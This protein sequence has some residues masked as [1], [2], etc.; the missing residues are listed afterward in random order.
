MK[1]VVALGASSRVVHPFTDDC[2]LQGIRWD[3]ADPNLPSSS[4]RADT[5][6]AFDFTVTVL[7]GMEGRGMIHRTPTKFHKLD[8]GFRGFIEEIGRTVWPGLYISKGTVYKAL[9]ELDIGVAHYPLVQGARGPFENA[10]YASHAEMRCNPRLSYA[11]YS[12][13]PYPRRKESKMRLAY[14]DLINMLRGRYPRG[15]Q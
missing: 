13:G 1:R 4:N 14:L 11:T 10:H 9:L 15:A 2:Y 7:R 3:E 12:N 5:R 8:A 6:E